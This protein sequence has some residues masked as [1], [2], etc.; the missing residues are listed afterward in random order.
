VLYS[1]RS[2]VERSKIHLDAD[3]LLID[4]NGSL[5]AL[6]CKASEVRCVDG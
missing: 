6:V 1:S 4:N 2:V 5:A 3:A